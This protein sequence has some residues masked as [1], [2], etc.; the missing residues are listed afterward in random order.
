M[1]DDR[2]LLAMVKNAMDAGASGIAIG[3]NVWQHAAP[4]A[5]AAAM[6]AI[7]HEDVSVESALKLI[8]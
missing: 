6:N 7:V 5:M 3:R 8:P 2:A 1:G 4:P